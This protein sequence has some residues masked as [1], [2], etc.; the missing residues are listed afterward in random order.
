MKGLTVFAVLSTVLFTPVLA[1]A[2]QPGQDRPDKE[3]VGRVYDIDYIGGDAGWTQI[4]IQP[5][6]G[7]NLVVTTKSELLQLLLEV[8]LLTRANIHITYTDANSAELRSASLRPTN[9]CGDE[10][11]VEEV[12]CRVSAMSCVARIKGQGAE[13]RTD[14]PRAFGILLTAIKYKKAV[15]NLG[16]EA[17]GS[18][19]RIKINVPN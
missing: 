10:G 4:L 1:G 14:N 16:V 7:P 3:S 9:A 18:I 15:E 17:T 11:C 13:I 5:A 19:R 6:A 2:L 8:A 12:S